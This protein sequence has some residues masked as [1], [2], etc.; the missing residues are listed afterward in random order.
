[1][2]LQVFKLWGERLKQRF[3][4]LTYKQ[5]NALYQE[6]KHLSDDEFAKACD[7]LLLTRN[8]NHIP[9]AEDFKPEEKV[10]SISEAPKKR[11]TKKGAY[12]EKEYIREVHKWNDGSGI[13]KQMEK[14]G[15]DSWVE[16]M[17][18]IKNAD[19]K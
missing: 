19:Q 6:L 10:I 8:F 12:G 2:Q 18:K 1:M 3:N 13:K 17:N 14:M 16:A 9:T 15:V 7:R 4:R 5:L 11:A